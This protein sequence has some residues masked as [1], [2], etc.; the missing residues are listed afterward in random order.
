MNKKSSIKSQFGD[1]ITLDQLYQICHISK[2]K[3]KWLLDNKVIPCEDSGKKTWRYRIKTDDVIE[4]L[5]N[6][7]IR[8][9]MAPVG[10]F[11]SQQA[12]NRR[13][14]ADEFYPLYEY[15]S[16][17]SHI[18]QLRNYY[19]KLFKQFPDGLTT[20]DIAQM[21][22]FTKTAINGWIQNGYLKAYH[23]QTNRIPKTYLLDFVCSNYY[24]KMHTRS[25]SQREHMLNFLEQIL[26]E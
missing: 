11:S 17:D 21:T 5:Q 14:K 12:G 18:E 4:Y 6:C 8:G 2:R 3:A 1:V 9:D 25:A 22:G 7:E 10:I 19:I 26:K 23:G 13:K 20:T 24:I 15:L 16:I